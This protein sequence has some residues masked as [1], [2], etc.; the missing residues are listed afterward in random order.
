ML[1]KKI[2]IIVKIKNIKK[3]QKKT[4]KVVKKCQKVVKK[5]SK[6]CQKGVRKLSKSCQK[7]NMK[8][9]GEGEE[10]GGEEEGDLKFL[11]QVRPRRTW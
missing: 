7:N 5:V 6:S 3:N 8:R 10:G 2:S 11:D 4:G 1:I 9:V